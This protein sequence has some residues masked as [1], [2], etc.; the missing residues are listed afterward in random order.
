MVPSLYSGEVVVLC[1]RNWLGNLNDRCVGQK[2]CFLAPK[3]MRCAGCNN[4]SIGVM[5]S[6]R[7]GVLYLE[8]SMLDVYYNL[9]RS[10]M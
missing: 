10:G 9:R 3:L 7:L 1:D 8:A 2:E 5:S 4:K 6:V